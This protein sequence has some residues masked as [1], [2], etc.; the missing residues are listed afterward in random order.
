MNQDKIELISDQLL[1]LKDLWSLIRSNSLEKSSND[2][3]EEL[4]I[5]MLDIKQKELR[6]CI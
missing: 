3:I 2:R 4:L 1:A 5:E 6:D